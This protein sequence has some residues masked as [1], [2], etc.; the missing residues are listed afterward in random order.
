M[1][2]ETAPFNIR[3]L[4]VVLG[5]FNTNFTKAASIARTEPPADYQGSQL[6]TNLSGLKSGYKPE[7]DP[8]KA[9]QAIYEMIA[10]EGVGE[11]KEAETVLYL[12]RDIWRVMN[13]VTGATSHALE[14][15]RDVCNNV[16]LDE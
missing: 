16:Y 7:G 2:K 11:G 4:N 3:T 15:S 12:G 9:A 13:I 1:G 10:G 5:G 14:A 6:R 8:A